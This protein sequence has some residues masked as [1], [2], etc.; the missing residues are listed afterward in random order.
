M[1]NK[2]SF[3]IRDG[4]EIGVGTYIHVIHPVPMF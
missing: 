2:V 3:Y 4:F 1:D